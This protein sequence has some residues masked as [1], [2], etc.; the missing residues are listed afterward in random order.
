MVIWVADR[1]VFV[2]TQGTQSVK[3][4]TTANRR[5]SYERYYRIAPPYV[6]P[7]DQISVTVSAFA[8]LADLDSWLINERKASREP[9]NEVAPISTPPETSLAQRERAEEDAE[10]SE[11]ASTVLA[12][13]AA[14]A[15]VLNLLRSHAYSP[16]KDDWL[17]GARA[18]VERA[19]NCLL[20]EFL[21]AP[22]L[23]RVE[24]SMHAYLYQILVRDS[25]L[26]VRVPIGTGLA[27]CQLVHKEW[28]ET[29]AREGNRRGSFDLAVL[30]PELLKGC[31]SLKTFREGR[32]VA[33]IVI[34]MGLD[35]DAEHL[36][37]DAKKLINSRPKYGYL[38]HLVREQPRCEDSEEILT[39][40]EKKFGVGTAYA[41]IAGRAK[42]Y[43][44]V[45]ESDITEINCGATI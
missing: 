19:I 15:E 40:M 8:T 27:E 16:D 45:G 35:Y 25:L 12:D 37:G 7:E 42:A 18:V 11:S 2:K 28:P 24:H 17:P 31:A 23:H 44:L 41:W 1:R 20:T 34:E 10:E 29:I 39:G 21:S 33:P 38:I 9:Q 43:K 22:Y 13:T 36:A 6:L 5:G 14:V 26:S 4:C 3:V 32:L 30:S